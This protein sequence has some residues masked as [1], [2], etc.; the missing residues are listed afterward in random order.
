MKQT[1]QKQK[2]TMLE[3]NFY[4]FALTYS[5]AIK[6]GHCVTVTIEYP[7]RERAESAQD[8]LR[9]LAKMIYKNYISFLH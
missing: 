4:P 7:N 1:T 3:A 8:T 6:Y 5:D 9:I 2:P